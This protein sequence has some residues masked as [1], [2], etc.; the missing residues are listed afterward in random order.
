MMPLDVFYTLD[1]PKE[2]TTWDARVCK[3]TWAGLLKCK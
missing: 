3:Q 1:I 2:A